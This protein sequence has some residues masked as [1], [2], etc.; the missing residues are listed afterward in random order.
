M[1]EFHLPKSAILKE[2]YIREIPLILY[3]LKNK[4]KFKNLEKLHDNLLT[5]RIAT[6]TA[7]LGASVEMIKDIQEGITQAIL[8]LDPNALKTETESEEAEGP[9]KDPYDQLEQLQ[10]VIAQTQK[11]KRTKQRN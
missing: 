11:G 2:F 9:K 4:R 10:G 8:R 1:D 6:A 5:L 7:G 3:R